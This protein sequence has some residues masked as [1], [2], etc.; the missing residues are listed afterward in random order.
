MKSNPVNAVFI[1]VRE[2]L[3]ARYEVIGTVE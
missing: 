2:I 1:R 3:T